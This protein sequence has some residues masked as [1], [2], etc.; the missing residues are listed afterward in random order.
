MKVKYNIRESTRAKNVSITV[1]LD[2][3]VIVVKPIG[4][5]WS[6]MEKFIGEKKSWIFK[7]VRH[8]QKLK[9]KYGVIPLKPIHRHTKKNYLKHKEETRRLMHER[10]E[11][12]NKY[13][14]FPIKRIAIKNQRRCWGSCS[15]NGN[16]NFNYRLLFLPEHLRDYIIVH[17]LC[18]LREL[19]HSKRFWALVERVVPNHKAIRKQLKRQE[20]LFQ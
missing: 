5:K 12:F 15:E 8:F 7:T 13:Y 1:E 3:S 11:H 17:E 10:V 6:V 14:S 9:E 18:H 20:L 4:M 16:L 19:N 2:G